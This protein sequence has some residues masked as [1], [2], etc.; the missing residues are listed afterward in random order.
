MILSKEGGDTQPLI[1]RTTSVLM[2][3]SYEYDS[4][5]ILE[6]VCKQRY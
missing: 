4:F 1:L 5:K 6:C 2:P 3:V